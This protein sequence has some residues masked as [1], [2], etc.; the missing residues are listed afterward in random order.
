MSSSI[1]EVIYYLKFLN[2]IKPTELCE[3]DFERITTWLNTREDEPAITVCDDNVNVIEEVQDSMIAIALLR[4][5]KHVEARDNCLIYNKKK[6]RF[7]NV[8]TADE[9]DNLVMQTV[10]FTNKR[11]AAKKD[12]CLI[13]HGYSGAGKSTLLDRVLA[14][15]VVHGK[16]KLYEVYLNKYFVYYRGMKCE[17]NSIADD[18]YVFECSNIRGVIEKFARKRSNGINATSS[19]SHTV[20]EVIYD[21][22]SLTCIDLC[23]NERGTS[24]DLKEETNFINTSLFNLSRFLTLGDKYKDKQCKLLEVIRRSKNILLTVIFHDVS[25]NLSVNHLLLLK[26]FLKS[27]MPPALKLLSGHAMI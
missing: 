22:Y 15:Q 27:I 21:G 7:N 6:Y 19:R 20:L 14:Q 2:F 12:T 4:D 24:K 13:Y 16:F 17:T 26:S 25:S 23:G 18:A 3:E 10:D 5:A 1:D 11:L 9:Y 8:Y